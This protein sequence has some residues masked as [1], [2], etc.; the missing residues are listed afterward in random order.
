[1]KTLTASLLLAAAA[2]STTAYAGSNE[3]DTPIISTLQQNSSPV[4]RAEVQGEMKGQPADQTSI[5]AGRSVNGRAA[6]NAAGEQV[7]K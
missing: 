5:E 4:T 7:K 1:M 6:G 3:V 2:L